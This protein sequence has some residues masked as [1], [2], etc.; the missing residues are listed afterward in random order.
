MASLEYPATLSGRTVL[1]KFVYPINASSPSPEI[2]QVTGT[3]NSWNRSEPLTLNIATS[4]FEGDISIN[5]DS[6]QNNNNSN[7]INNNANS[8]SNKVLFKFVLDNSN[9][10]TDPNQKEERDQAG[11]LYNVIFVNTTTAPIL[12]HDSH[13]SS[14]AG[15][16]SSSSVAV[17]EE[18]NQQDDEEDEEERL[19]Q[20]KR[21]AEDEAIIRELGGG[22][23]GTPYFA[24]NDPVDL[25]EHFPTNPD[26]DLSDDTLTEESSVE[27]PIESSIEKPEILQSHEKAQ[28][29]SA[30]VTAEAVSEKIEETNGE[31]NEEVQ[32]EEED[33][34]DK[35][36]REL[37]GTM[38]G[39]PYFQVNDPILDDYF[40]EALQTSTSDGEVSVVAKDATT[41]GKDLYKGEV[42]KDEIDVS[43]NGTLLETVVETVEDVVTQAPDG[44]ILEEA[45]STNVQESIS[46]V[47]EESVTETVET[48][49]EIEPVAENNT[50]VDAITAP[51][52]TAES[53][54]AGIVM[55]ETETTLSIQGEDGLE[56][57]IVE[58]TIT[59]TD[60]P[61][62]NSDS[63][64]KLTTGTKPVMRGESFIMVQQSPEVIVVSV[65][66]P[67]CTC[68]KPE[69][70]STQ[71]LIDIPTTPTTNYFKKQQ[72][73]DSNNVKTAIEPDSE[74]D[75][76]VLLLQG[77]PISP[78]DVVAANGDVKQPVVEISTTT[79]D[80]KRAKHDSI[81]TI[82]SADTAY[83]PTSATS[84]V[85]APFSQQ[86]EKTQKK[87][88]WKK[89]RKV[90]S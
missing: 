15:S 35:I 3:F 6:L 47:A 64:Y 37:G 71:Q 56:A 45:I 33:E 18:L 36:I 60:G 63:L 43:M 68:P 61:E 81:A 77:Q 44:T 41:D 78:S 86:P 38:W 34:D 85:C 82:E 9:W 89:I 31:Q 50:T 87:T 32:E 57:S 21:E 17:N 46:G 30:T 20:L 13:G 27:S 19:A 76:N 73:N 2:V 39:T 42:L 25:P 72:P 11:N 8:P 7:V 22:M 28:S 10:V 29:I 59:F 88:L 58:D 4:Q 14:A 40:P 79:I 1:V 54:E 5:L 48:I 90:L 84:T 67:G 23:W 52:V 51:T 53:P 75:H 26:Q 55:T 16:S 70:E 12:G 74:S 62:V 66:S 69:D 83:T 65:A 49:E 80:V 24:V